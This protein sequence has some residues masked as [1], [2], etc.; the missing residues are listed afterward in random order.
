LVLALDQF[1]AGKMFFSRRITRTG[2]F[3]SGPEEAVQYGLLLVSVD[4]LAPEA[5]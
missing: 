4:I 3:G 1:L 2:R 5:G